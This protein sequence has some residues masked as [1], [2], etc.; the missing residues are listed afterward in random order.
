MTVSNVFSHNNQNSF[1]WLNTEWPSVSLSGLPWETIINHK[2][3]APVPNQT[4]NIRSSVIFISK[5]VSVF[6][7]W[8]PITLL[9]SFFTVFAW[10]KVTGLS[11]SNLHMLKLPTSHGS[12]WVEGYISATIKLHFVSYFI[13][14]VIHCFEQWSWFC[15][16]YLRTPK[17]LSE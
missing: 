5:K 1:S 15:K 13:F 2:L 10:E 17:R 14:N 7:H 4:Q 9:I 8:N 16:G 3:K 6:S 12:A 11:L